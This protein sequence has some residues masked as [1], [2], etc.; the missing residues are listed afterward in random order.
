VSL[1]NDLEREL[2][3]PVRVRA[4]APGSLTV[5]LNGEQIFSKKQAGRSPTSAEI[6]QTVRA[7]TS[8]T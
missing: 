6:V 1:R 8:Q 4:G 3:V 2:G 5:L 7:R